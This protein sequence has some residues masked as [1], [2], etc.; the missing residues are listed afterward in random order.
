VIAN[1]LPD[2]TVRISVKVGETLPNVCA[3]GAVY[4]PDRI[5]VMGYQ[6]GSFCPYCKEF[7][8]HEE[9]TWDTRKPD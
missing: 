8:P 9:V 6:E 7:S 4:V 1:K 5:V 3:C 2:G